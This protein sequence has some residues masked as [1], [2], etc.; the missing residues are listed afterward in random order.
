M[1]QFTQMQ[2]LFYARMNICNCVFIG[3]VKKENKKAA[4]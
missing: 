3:F 4:F 1:N 2:P